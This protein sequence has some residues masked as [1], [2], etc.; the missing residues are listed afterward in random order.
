M[1]LVESESI[2]EAAD[3]FEVF[4]AF[5]R[6]YGFSLEDVISAASEKRKEKGGFEKGIILDWVSEYDKE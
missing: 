1:E 3:V 6:S 2:E 4:S 5:S